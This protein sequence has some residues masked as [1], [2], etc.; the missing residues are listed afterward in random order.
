MLHC[1][2]TN[3]QVNRTE[4]VITLTVGSRQYGWKPNE[5]LLEMMESEGIVK[6]V[7]PLHGIYYFYASPIL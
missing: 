2:E 7:F 1:D 3:V 5:S 4:T 6:Q